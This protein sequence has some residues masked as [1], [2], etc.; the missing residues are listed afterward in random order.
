MCRNTRGFTVQKDTLKVTS[1]SITG[2]RGNVY[3]FFL[4]NSITGDV[5]IADDATNGGGYHTYIHNNSITGNTSITNNG[6]TNFYDADGAGNGNIY[7]GNLIYNAAGSGSLY[8]AQNDALQ[9]TGNLTIN[10]TATGFTQAFNSGAVIGGNFAYTNNFAGTTYLGNNLSKTSIT[11]TVN[12]AINNTTPDIFEIHRLVNQTT[13]GNINVQNTRGFTVQK[14]TLKV[15]SLSITGYRGNV[16]GF[17]WRIPL[18]AMF[19]IA[20]DASNGGGYYTYIRNNLITGNTSITTS[21]TNTF[22]DADGA[23][24]SNIYEGNVT[25]VRNGAPINVGTG[26]FIEITKNLTLNSA[27]GITLGKIKFNGSTNGVIEQLGTQP[28]NIS[29][30]TM[31]KTGSGKITLNDPVTVTTTATFTSG[32]IFSSAANNL[33]FPD[34]ISYTGASDASYVDGIVSKI[35]MMHLYSR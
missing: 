26:A 7:T 34:N 6:T 8:I 15:T 5:T 31:V 3:G 13:G 33:I 20:D 30:L 25:Y 18:Q 22:Y 32:N 29:E 12:I 19:T 16:Y 4:E 28:V 1:L 21:G 14:D 27:S 11:G 23:G 9:C 17:S 24:Y 10:R 2:Y 35:G